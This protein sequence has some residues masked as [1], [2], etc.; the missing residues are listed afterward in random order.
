MAAS[1]YEAGFDSL[2]AFQLGLESAG[3]S[4]TRTLV[5]HV[6]SSD[7]PFAPLWEEVRQDASDFVYAAYCGATAGDF[8]RAYSASGLAG[9]VPLAGCAYLCAD[10]DA[11]ST[12]VMPGVVSH[13]PWTGALSAGGAWADAYATRMGR[14][15]D[16]FAA[17]GNEIARWLAASWD[18]A[19]GN[20]AHVL[21]GRVSMQT[22][23]T[24]GW[25]T[26]CRMRTLGAT[27]DRQSL[28]TVEPISE[29]DERVSAFQTGIKT[30]WL[31][32]YLGI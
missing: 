14:P 1:L 17:Q 7:A 10:L 13:V 30:G 4:V 6:T 22:H 29:L 23:A 18:A 16:A 31:Y 21:E 24:G 5:T 15:A 19:Q 9:R 26:L 32:P 11:Q 3:G 12:L 27:L 28:E 8:L 25:L 20:L 2:Y